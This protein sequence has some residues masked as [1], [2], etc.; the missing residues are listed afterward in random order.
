MHPLAWFTGRVWV[1]AQMRLLTLDR[2]AVVFEP[3][4]PLAKLLSAYGQSH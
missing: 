4:V 3:V 1:G 2:R